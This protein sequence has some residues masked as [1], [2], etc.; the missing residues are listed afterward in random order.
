[1]LK[2]GQSAE[3]LEI[4]VSLT[5]TV[6]GKVVSGLNTPTKTTSAKLSLE[7]DLR[8]CLERCWLSWSVKVVEG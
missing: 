7:V 5:P 1:M 2:K 4:I 3:R 8:L 6:L